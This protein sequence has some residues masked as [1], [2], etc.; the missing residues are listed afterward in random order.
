MLWVLKRI[1]KLLQFYAQE[2]HLSGPIS[3]GQVR[4]AIITLHLNMFGNIL[5]GICRDYADIVQYRKTCYQV[6]FLWIE[7]KIMGSVKQF[8][9]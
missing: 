5:K 4:M 2:F 7:V 8:E 3:F 6:F 9:R 1:R